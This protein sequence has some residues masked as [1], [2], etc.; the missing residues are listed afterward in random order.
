MEIFLLNKKDKFHKKKIY[1]SFG[2][3]QVHNYGSTPSF[4]IKKKMI[5]NTKQK[6]QK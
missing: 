6:R 5:S 1:I 4:F 3:G 2:W